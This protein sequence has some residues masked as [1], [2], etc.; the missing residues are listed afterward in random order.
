MKHEVV[1]K[2]VGLMIILVLVALSFGGLAQIVP[3]FFIK[4][5][6]TPIEGLKPLP[7][8]VLEGRDIY[9]REGCAG[10]DAS[11]LS[12]RGG[13]SPQHVLHTLKAMTNMPR[14]NIAPPINR[15]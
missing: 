12:G 4:S 2:N 5:T 10:V 11:V 3:L 9:I 15:T 7:A 8:L 1:E 13:T 6:T 14:K